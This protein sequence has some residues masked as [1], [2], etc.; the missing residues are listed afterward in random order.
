VSVHIQADTT[1]RQPQQQQQQQQSVVLQL[2]VEECE[3]RIVCARTRKWFD[4]WIAVIAHKL[5]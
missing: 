4:K 2:S 3:H 1:Q 5:E